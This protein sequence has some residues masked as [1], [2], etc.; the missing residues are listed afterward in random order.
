MA[1][2]R[3]LLEQLYGV[4]SMAEEILEQEKQTG[5]WSCCH[6]AICFLLSKLR[7]TP[8]SLGNGQ[9]KH[10]APW[11]KAHKGSRDK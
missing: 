6:S 8:P 10:V 11:D 7:I 5:T 1:K 3:K 4:R 2:L 9:T